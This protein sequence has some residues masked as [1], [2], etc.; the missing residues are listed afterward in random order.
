MPI[1]TKSVYTHSNALDVHL[2]PRFATFLLAG[3]SAG[4]S[5]DAGIRA[6]ESE[7][8]GVPNVVIILADDLG[9]GDL[10]CYG[11]AMFKTPHLDKAARDCM[12]TW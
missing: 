9:Y 12:A 4:L 5:A 2:L 3:L 11:H 8:Q 10:A 1:L 6:A 7:P